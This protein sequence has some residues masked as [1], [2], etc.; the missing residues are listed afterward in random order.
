MKRD[1]TTHLFI[2]FT[3]SALHACGGAGAPYGAVR[4]YVWSFQGDGDAVEEDENQ[5]HVVEQFVRYHALAPRTASARTC[6]EKTR[7]LKELI[8]SH[9][10]RRA[11]SVFCV[12]ATYQKL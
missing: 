1:F 8:Q 2:K 11:Y 4:Q 3:R 9:A 5:N 10:L 6:T 7:R 12:F